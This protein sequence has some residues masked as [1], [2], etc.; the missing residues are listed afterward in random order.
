M[1]EVDGVSV[2]F[3]TGTG[4][5]VALDNVSVTIGAQEFFT[6]LGPSGCGKTTLLRAIA[7]FLRPG[8]GAIR[9][10]GE[11]LLGLPPNQRPVN[12]VFQNYALFP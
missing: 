2:R 9:L 10:E 11:D 3:G 1:I 5:F 8:A 6:L 7:G 12:T 4:A